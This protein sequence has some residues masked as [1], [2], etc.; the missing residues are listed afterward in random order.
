MITPAKNSD[1][2]TVRNITH[3]TIREIYVHY[4]PKGA[5]EF[6]LAHHNDAAICRDIAENCVY[7]CCNSENVP[8]GTVTLNGNEINRLFVLPQ[9]QGL[10]F[11]SELM[12]FAESYIFQKYD[13]ISLSASLSAKSIYLKYGYTPV[14]FHTIKCADGDFLCYDIMTKHLD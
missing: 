9:Y 11:G 3:N 1:I 13:T 8:V 14:E 4:Y 12:K 2:G 10:G 5:V 7:L 6:F